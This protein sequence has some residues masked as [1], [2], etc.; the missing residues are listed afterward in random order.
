MSTTLTRVGARLLVAPLATSVLLLAPAQTTNA[1]PAAPTSA[2]SAASTA[3][4][5]ASQPAVA[6]R[7]TRAER[8]AKR[9]RFGNR[10]VAVARSRAGSPYRYGATGPRAFDCSGLTQWVFRKVGKHL[11][12]TSR[13]QAGAVRRVKH[14]RRGDLVFFHN[15]GRVY[16]VGIYA[17]RHRLWHSSRPGTPVQKSKIWSNSVFYGRVR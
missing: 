1:A 6:Q 16:H 10:V 5:A 9:K 7:Q 11:P 8:V 12:R 13:A 15:G 17:G 14:P 2:A 4:V 3:S